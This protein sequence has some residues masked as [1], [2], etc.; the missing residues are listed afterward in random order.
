MGDRNMRAT[1]CGFVL[2][3]RGGVG[4]CRRRDGVGTKK[5]YI[6]VILLYFFSA[7]GQTGVARARLSPCII[8]GPLIFFSLFANPSKRE[9]VE[10]N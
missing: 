10:F 8:Y 4:R 5:L 7:A 1:D 3:N 6:V 2:H 9:R